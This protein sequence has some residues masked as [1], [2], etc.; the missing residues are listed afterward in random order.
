MLIQ[1]RDKTMAIRPILQYPEQEKTLRKT[2]TPVTKFDRN[3]RRLIRDL[4]DT[5]TA[6]PAV[7]L[8]AI[9][10][11][12]PARIFVVRFGQK[13]DGSGNL[14][15]PKVFI[16]PTIVKQGPLRKDYDGC[17]SIKSLQGYTMRPD[18]ITIKAM[19]ENGI[20]FTDTWYGLD[21]RAIHHENDHLDG[22]LFIDLIEDFHNDLFVLTGNEK[23]YDFVPYDTFQQYIA[24]IEDNYLKRTLQLKFPSGVMRKNGKTNRV[25][26]PVS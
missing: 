7:G 16:N 18:Y 6:S 22:I 11:G 19:D 12:V 15:K 3:L 21:A 9:Q 26:L 13:S 20:V 2:S 10:I 1:Q 14:E 5:V 4:K 25:R 24:Q 8:A 17:L 23:Y